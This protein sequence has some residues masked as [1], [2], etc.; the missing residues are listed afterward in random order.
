MGFSFK[1]WKVFRTQMQQEGIT[2]AKFE[3]EYYQCRFGM[4]YSAGQNVFWVAKRGT[5]SAFAIYLDWYHAS[6]ILDKEPYRQLAVCK[7]E[8]F[9]PTKPY[10]PF[11]FLKKLD[12]YIGTAPAL[13][14]AT[15]ADFHPV[16][17]NAIPDEEKIYFQRFMPHTPGTK[18]VTGANIAKVRKI[19]GNT[20]AEFC[21][22]N[23][24]SVAFTD[25]PTERSFAM[26]ENPKKVLEEQNADK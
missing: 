6:V 14:R 24:V 18:H 2:V 5:Q 23:N 12:D 20:I 11:D 8:A 25:Q 3:F 1:N 17:R 15:A 13:Q 9:D 7:G 19:L 26:I 10:N 4:V 22:E 16:A 21:K